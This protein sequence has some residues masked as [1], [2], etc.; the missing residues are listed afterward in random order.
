M[1]YRIRTQF[2]KRLKK[3][4]EQ[5]ELLLKLSITDKLTLVYN[6]AKLDDRL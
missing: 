6:R 5:N 4:A 2:G 1:K 3:M